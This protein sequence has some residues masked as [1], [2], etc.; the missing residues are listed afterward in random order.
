[1]KVDTRI[2]IN[3]PT[4][5]V[6]KILTDTQSYP[7][8]NPLIKELKGDLK[9]GEKLEITV[10]LNPKSTNK[11]K[12]TVISYR[13]GEEFSW[14][15]SLPI[16]G[17]FE[18]CHYFQLEAQGEQTLFKHSETFSGLL[19]PL[20]KKTVLAAEAGF[21]KMNQALKERVELRR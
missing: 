3:A 14:R 12:P 1:M 13:K 21:N 11:F 15:G 10:Q 9:L 20:M 16:P 7:E 6:W 5:K 18:G 8:W 4:A 19:V 2:K 17:L